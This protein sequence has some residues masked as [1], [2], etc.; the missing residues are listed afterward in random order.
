MLFVV[1][2]FFMTGHLIKYSDDTFII[3]LSKKCGRF[4]VDDGLRKGGV[5]H[6]RAYMM[7]IHMNP[8]ACFHTH[9]I[10]TTVNI[11]SIILYKTHTWHKQLIL[12]IKHLHCHKKPFK[13]TEI[14]AYTWRR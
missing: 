9:I 1:G 7:C 8:A 4:L 5:V 14:N 11:L 3:L 2:L 12:Y 13:I 10:F 6:L